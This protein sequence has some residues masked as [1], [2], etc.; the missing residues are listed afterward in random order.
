M[1]DLI[2]IKNLLIHIICFSHSLPNVKIALIRHKHTTH[3]HTPCGTNIKSIATHSTIGR[4]S[5]K[6]NLVPFITL[7]G[8][9]TAS[10]KQS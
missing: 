2:V 3:T 7:T 1:N 9:F 4:I 5:I 6:S 8:M 10:K